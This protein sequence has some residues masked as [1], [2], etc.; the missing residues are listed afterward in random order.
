[1]K[2]AVSAKEITTTST[3]CPHQEDEESGWTS[4]FDD[5]SVANMEN[6]FGGGSSLVSDAASCAAW[7]FSSPN[8]IPK[9]LKFKKSR[10]K[11]ISEL[12]HSLEDTAS[13]PVNSPKVGELN[14]TEMNSRK[15]ELDDDD[16]INS[17]MDKRFASGNYSEVQRDNRN[18]C[19]DLKKKG[20]CL[21]PLSM[22]V[23]YYG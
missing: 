23:N 19:T 21:V 10:T 11:E 4:Y 12:D 6:S 13:S 2:K 7:K 1:M 20:L 22:L 17:F 9:K 3:C 8:N 15:T 14:S 18:D 5:F 16:H